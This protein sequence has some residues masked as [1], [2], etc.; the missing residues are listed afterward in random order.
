M[1]S[2]EKN[3]LLTQTGPGTPGGELMRR[4]WHPAALSE[5]L[6]PGGAPLPVRLLS[7]DLVLFRDEREQLGLLGIHCSHRAADL[8]YGRIEDGGLRCLYHG[9]LYDVAGNC[10]EQPGEPAGSDFKSKIHHPAYP[11][12]ERS[13]VIFAYLGPG[14][15]PL[16]PQYEFLTVADEHVFAG[17]L[18]SECNYLQGNEGNLDLIHLSFLHYNSYRDAGGLDGPIEHLS[19]QGAAPHLET[20]EV[21]PAAYGLKVCKIRQMDEQKHLYL[22][23]Y[24][25]PS[26]FAFSGNSRDGYSLNW[27]VPIDDTHHW[28]YTF[29]F[30]RQVALD[31]DMIRRGRVAVD[32]DYKS[33]RT[34]ANRYLQDRESM[35]TDSYTGIGLI[36]QVQDL[37]ATEGEGAIQDRTQERLTSADV[38]LIVMRDIMLEGIRSVQ[39]GQDPPHVMRDPEQNRF[40][41]VFASTALVPKDTDW[42][43]YYRPD[44]GGESGNGVEIEP[45]LAEKA[46]APHDAGQRSV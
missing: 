1:L 43:A 15:P 25:I 6:P 41:Q 18:F 7:E 35:R 29:I 28:K 39:E 44:S 19:G 17:K 9:W 5:E 14:E 10:L 23:T 22:G 45:F 2:E 37:C 24:V 8:S 21:D 27:H 26:A 13:G 34:A 20:V 38:P 16:F 46:F 30:D 36:F 40:P 31:K 32:A 3:R 33:L 12:V 4:Y 11:C 42:R